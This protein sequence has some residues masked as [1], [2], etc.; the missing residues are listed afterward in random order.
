LQKNSENQIDIS[1]IIVTWNSSS[2]IRNCLHSIFNFNS[3]Y[4]TEIIIIDNA[5]EDNT[6]EIIKQFSNDESNDIKLIENKSN[7]GFTSANNTGLRISKGKYILLLNPDTEITKDSLKIL[8]DFLEKNINTGAVAPQLLNQDGSIQFSCRTFPKYRDMF[9]EMLLISKVFSKS[10]FFSGWKMKY[11]S[12]NE[13][14]KVDQPMAAALLIKSDLIKN[15]NYFD[16]QFEMFFNDVDLCRK[17]YDSGSEIFFI[18][19]SKVYH[20]KGA[21]IFRN[22]KKMIDTWNNDCLNYFRKYHYNFLQFNLLKA[23]L[24]FTGFFRKIFSTS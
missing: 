1:I 8:I 19:G 5:S 6:I 23:G 17:I 12:H 21:S 2:E 4:K 9:F 15:I 7:E 18:P 20:I 22:R 13:V 10:R 11:F 3:E 24:Y 14:R 16:P